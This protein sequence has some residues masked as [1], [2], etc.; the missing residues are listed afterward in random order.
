[1]PLSTPW[2]STRSTDMVGS[3]PV[4]SAGPG[5]NLAVSW[6]VT[7]FPTPAVDAHGG[8]PVHMQSKAKSS[9]PVGEMSFWAAPAYATGAEPRCFCTKPTWRWTW[10]TREPDCLHARKRT[11]RKVDS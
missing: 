4:K 3:L 7:V 5:F 10:Q 9:P 8:L 1:M 2:Q 6:G 11:L